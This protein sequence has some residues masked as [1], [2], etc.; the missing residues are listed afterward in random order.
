MPF[1]VDRKSRVNPPTD[2]MDLPSDEVEPA[3]RHPIPRP[4]KG[5]AEFFAAASRRSQASLAKNSTVPGD[6]RRGRSAFSALRSPMPCSVD[7]KSRVD[8]PTG[9]MDL[10]S[11]EVDPAMRHPSSP[12]CE[13][14]SR[15]FRD[16]VAQVA[17]FTREKLDR[18]RGCPPGTLGFFG[19]WLAYALRR[20]P[21]KPG[22]PSNR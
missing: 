20:R 12:S 1:S 22:G 13:G 15:V 17:S 6:A 3:M 16:C 2:R 10:P 7:R 19:R 14:Y 9:R 18:P 5:T 11:D 4:V 8:P 21:K